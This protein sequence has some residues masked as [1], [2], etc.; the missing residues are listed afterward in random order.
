MI[1]GLAVL[2]LRCDTDLELLAKRLADRILGCGRLAQDVE[3]EHVAVPLEERGVGGKRLGG[4][5]HGVD[6]SGCCTTMK[7]TSRYWADHSARDFAHWRAS[8]LVERIVAV[9]PLGATEQHG[10]HL[11]CGVDTVLT[12]GVLR[13]ALSLVPADVPVLALPTLA[14]GLSP[15]H[16]R[17]AGTLTLRSQTVLQ[18]WTDIGESVAAAGVRK[19]LLFNGHGG[20]QGALDLVARDLRARCGLQVWWTSWMQLPLLDEHGQRHDWPFSA[21]EQRFGIHAGAIETSMMLALAPQQVDMTRAQRFG[22]QA[23]QRA[24]RGGLLGDGRSAKLGWQMQD[25]NLAGAAGDASAASAEQGE[26]MVRGSARALAQL[27]VEIHDSPSDTLND[28]VDL[29]LG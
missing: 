2:G 11:S 29:G 6:N 16:A 13:S 14:V 17:F 5:R 26:R 18:L 9:L 4:A 21:D 28:H 20:H 12:E 7:L 25:I 24:Q 22:S 19:L 3:H 27:L 8:G 1:G 23:E 10:P 15:E